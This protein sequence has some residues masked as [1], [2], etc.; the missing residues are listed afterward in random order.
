MHVHV[1]HVYVYVEDLVT[2]TIF[3]FM[4]WEFDID[5]LRN[6]A[7]RIYDEIRHQCFMY[8][9]KHGRKELLKFLQNCDST[10]RRGRARAGKQA[11]C[12]FL[13]EADVHG[14]LRVPN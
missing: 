12:G 3:H 1:Q 6:R 7:A 2:N 9:F 5:S 10:T 14:Y 13:F 11:A 8:D 4:M